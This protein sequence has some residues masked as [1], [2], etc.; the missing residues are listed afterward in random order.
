MRAWPLPDAAR[1]L[2]KVH[3]VDGGDVF[4]GRQEELQDMAGA[5]RQRYPPQTPYIAQRCEDLH[6]LPLLTL[7]LP[8]CSG[9]V[10][11]LFYSY[12]SKLSKIYIIKKEREIETAKGS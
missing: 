9:T 1:G 7:L 6:P 4:A 3:G 2:A 8:W 10:L 12:K 11:L 5:G